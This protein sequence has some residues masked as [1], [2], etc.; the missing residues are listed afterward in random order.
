MSELSTTS[1]HDLIARYQAGDNHALD[2]LIRRTEERLEHFARRMLAGF[3]GVRAKEQTEDVLQDALLRLTRALRQETPSS[4]REFFGLAAVQIRRVL[5]DLARTH[6]RR[7]TESLA[8]DP[9]DHADDS[10][11]LDRWTRLHEAVE[12]LPAELR[13]VFSYT[14]YHGWTQGQI[15]EVL[16]ISDRQ[17]RR[18]WVQT[19]RQLK[20]AVGELP[21]E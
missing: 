11:E 13:D 4:V 6:A 18:L 12:Q 1:L 17:V 7:P 8:A 10:T 20:T 19:C 3:P 16:G 21:G 15:A 14:F 9:S 5:L 2:A